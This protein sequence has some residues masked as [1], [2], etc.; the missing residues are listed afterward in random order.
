MSD[1]SQPIRKE[2]QDSQRIF[3]LAIAWNW[4]CDRDFVFEIHGLCLHCGLKPYL[5]QP[6]NLYETLQLIS[7]EKIKFKVFFDRVADTDFR[8]SE[9][10]QLLQKKGTFFIND[11][12]RIK[13]IDD[14]VLIHMDLIFHKIPVPPTFIY[15]PHDEQP[16][17]INKI[18]QIGVPFVVKPAHGVETGGMGVLLDAYFVEDIYQWQ[19]QYKNFIFLIQKQVIPCTMDEKPAWFRVFYILEK[20]LACWWNP[21]THIY[22]AVTKTDVE[23]FNLKPLYTL[24]ERIEKLYK[25]GLF[26]TEIAVDN[27]GDF[28]VVDYINDQCDMRK[29]SKFIDGVCDEI[30]DLIVNR[31]VEK[32]Q[33][34]V[35]GDG[36]AQHD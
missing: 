18:K 21:S 2:E 4:E 6:F 9:L 29:K 27:T 13:W 5:V 14:K 16:V 8:F 28:L 11:P 3:D 26:S 7:E 22:E 30:V 24:A 25:L 33:K 12:D 15:Y 19:R 36:S 10:T 34:E 20:I 35:I 1:V 17:L 32:I 23:K 31:L